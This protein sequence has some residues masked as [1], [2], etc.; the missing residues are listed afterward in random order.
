[1]TPSSAPL[2]GIRVLDFTHVI[3]G[4]LATQILGDL[5][6]SVTKIEGL[7]GGDVG[8]DMAP[9][10]NGQSHY[11]VAF[12]R[13]KRSIAIDLKSEAGKA[14]IRAL[15]ANTD[16][17]VENFAPGVITRLGFGYEAVRD[18]NPAIVYCSISGFGQTGPLANKRSLDL[19]AQA[20]SGIMSTNGTPDGPPLKVGVPIGDTTSS[21][22][23]A[24]GILAA[25]HR[26]RT[27]GQGEYL[28]VAMYDSLLTLLANHGGY[29]RAT[30][31]Q[32][33]RA[34]SGHY[35]TV[36][37]GTFAAA[38]GEIVVAIMTDTNWARLCESLGLSELAADPQLKTLAGRA[39]H[40][41]RIYA[42]LTAVL[43]GHTVASLIERFGDN[44]VPCAPVNDI[45]QALHHPHTE[46]RGMNLRMEHPQ[47]GGVD[48]TS[49][50]LRTLM[51]E[52]HTAPPLRGE[53][54]MQVLRELGMTEAAIAKLLYDRTA[55]QS[56]PAPAVLQVMATA[57]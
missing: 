7:G 21:L 41:E 53:H 28:D 20:Y 56:A 36:P 24:I 22:F 10:R 51:R 33:E 42:E 54:T 6:A 52:Q 1:M 30:G 46:A 38:D 57:P 19:V 23:A 25:L 32:P 14:V 3:A 29:V 49:L 4:P 16:V 35:F 17:L 15:L 37:Y 26:R 31:T 34:G 55:W 40:K 48:A 50:P 13:N 2:D 43:R 9:M 27:T 18:I 44:D 11:F 45:T 8:R 5:G 39:Q 12:N 47:Y